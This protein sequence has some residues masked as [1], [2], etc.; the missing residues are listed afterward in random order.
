MFFLI[1][2]AYVLSVNTIGEM[3]S[4]FVYLRL[5]HFRTPL[6]LGLGALLLQL[7]V[8][9]YE[10][11][12]R[13]GWLLSVPA[14]QAYVDAIQSVAFALA[15]VLVYA[16]IR[17]Y[18]PGGIEQR[19]GQHLA[20]IARVGIYRRRRKGGERSE[21]SERPEGSRSERRERAV[22]RRERAERRD[23][24]ERERESA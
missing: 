15:T 5:D 20:A 11:L 2:I 16:T 8:F 24:R 13:E 19:I 17:R 10:F 21:R 22:E 18:T 23:R 4:E 12:A 1:R 7:L 3:W 14:A 9:V 6:V